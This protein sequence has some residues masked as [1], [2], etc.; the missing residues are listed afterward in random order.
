MPGNIQKQAISHI[1]VI[2]W[3]RNYTAC[4]LTRF[5][6]VAYNRIFLLFLPGGRFY[7]VI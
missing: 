1:V 4:I 6:D 2:L 7:N 3:D 5:D